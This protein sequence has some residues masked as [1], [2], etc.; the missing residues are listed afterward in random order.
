MRQISMIERS[1]R[2]A[3]VA[4]WASTLQMVFDAIDWCGLHLSSFVATALTSADEAVLECKLSE[5][6]CNRSIAIQVSY[7]E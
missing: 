6:F 5:A 7:A 1:A 3:A 4:L 2:A